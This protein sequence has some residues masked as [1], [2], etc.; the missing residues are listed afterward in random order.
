MKLTF[1]LQVSVTERRKFRRFSLNPM[2]E[3][4]IKKMAV[5]EWEV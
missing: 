1:M 3:A 2:A 5:F 4:K